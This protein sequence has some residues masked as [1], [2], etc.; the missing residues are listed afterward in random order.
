MIDF[1][2]H[3]DPPDQ[4]PKPSLRVVER[5]ARAE[6]TD[7]AELTPQLHEIVDADALD[8]LFDPSSRGDAIDRG[9][10]TFR[11]RGYTVTVHADG[12]IILE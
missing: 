5:I 1:E 4:E 2:P 6:G 10:I 8:Q 3:G 12:R 7:P 11:Y 9:S